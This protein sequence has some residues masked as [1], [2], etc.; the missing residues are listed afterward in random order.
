MPDNLTRQTVRARFE[1]ARTPDARKLFRGIIENLA[2]LDRRSEPGRDE[3]VAYAVQ[4]FVD[5]ERGPSVF[6]LLER[7]SGYGLEWPQKLRQRLSDRL[8]LSESRTYGDAAKAVGT[9]LLTAAKPVILE[10][11]GDLLPPDAKDWAPKLG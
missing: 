6:P 5:W 7:F 2:A 3:F 11:C 9:A 10:T 8:D 4:N 1:E